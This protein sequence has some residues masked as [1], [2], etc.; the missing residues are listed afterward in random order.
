MGCSGV[1]S[2]AIATSGAMSGAPV[3]QPGRRRPAL[4]QPEVRQP[5]LRNHNS[6]AAVHQGELLRSYS[7]GTGLLEMRRA[8]PMRRGPLGAN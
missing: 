3:N 1:S 5:E 7:K 6:L 4:R 2:G 8:N